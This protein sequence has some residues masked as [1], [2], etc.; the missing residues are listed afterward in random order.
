[1]SVFRITINHG[2]PVE[3]E[4]NR[5]EAFVNDSV[6][7]FNADQEAHW[8]SLIDRP[9]APNSPSNPVA[10]START[11]DYI[12]NLHPNETGQIIVKP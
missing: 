9:I 5:Q 12:C 8:P 7:W 2:P 1:M 6:F 4:P 10:F 11:I 3:F